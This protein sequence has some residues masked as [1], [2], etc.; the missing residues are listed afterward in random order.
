MRLR[1][2]STGNHA[3]LVF[4]RKAF[5]VDVED[6]GFDGR[7]ILNLNLKKWVRKRIDSVRIGKIEESL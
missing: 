4:Y 2:G 1:I 6:L 7:I 5:S 3:C